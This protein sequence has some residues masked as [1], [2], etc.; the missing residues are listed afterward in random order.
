MRGCADKKWRHTP[1]KGFFIFFFY[2]VRF[3][4]YMIERNGGGDQGKLFWHVLN[5]SLQN[6]SADKIFGS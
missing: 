6:I 4:I 5:F 2:S 1:K 3:Y